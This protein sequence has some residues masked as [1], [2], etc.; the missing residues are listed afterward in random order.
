MKEQ[1]TLIDDLQATPDALL[2]IEQV[3]QA[4]HQETTKRREFY[5]LVNEDHKAE[6]INGEIVFHSPVRKA[7]WHISTRLLT[8]LNTYVEE[9]DLGIVGA[10]KVIITL[11]RN[12]YEPDI[13][14]FRKEVAEQ[15]TND[16]LRF[17][18]PDFVVEILSEST[19]ERD[20]GIKMRDYAAHCIP[21][22]WII[23]PTQQ[24]IEQYWLDQHSYALHQKV[25]EGHLTA[26]IIA[27]FGIEVSDLFT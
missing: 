5:E 9:H 20:R 23:D 6:F 12:D 2:I 7:H 26:K 17:P 10:E 21:E 3:Q 14:Y 8:R 25:A 16:Q 11:S 13:C 4:I 22:Y 27:G 18:A 24:T 19:A 1:H 15:F